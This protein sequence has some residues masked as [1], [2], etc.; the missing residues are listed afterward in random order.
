MYYALLKKGRKYFR[1]TSRALASYAVDE[2]NYIFIISVSGFNLYIGNRQTELL[3]SKVKDNYM[4][5]CMKN[6][7]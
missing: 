5:R 6:A 3:P 7:K 4:A 2:F 1:T